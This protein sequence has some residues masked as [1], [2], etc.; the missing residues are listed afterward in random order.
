MFADITITQ[1]KIIRACFKQG[2]ANF[3]FMISLLL[4]IEFLLYVSGLLYI[5]SFVGLILKEKVMQN[6]NR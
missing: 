6:E 1:N 5:Y 3:L 2:I 4:R